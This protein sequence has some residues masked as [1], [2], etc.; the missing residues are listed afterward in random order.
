MPKS[1]P[2]SPVTLF[3]L[4]GV[5]GDSPLIRGVTESPLETKAAF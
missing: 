4:G 5:T 2:E 3:Y 1:H